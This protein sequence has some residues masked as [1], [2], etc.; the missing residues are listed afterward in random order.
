MTCKLPELEK[1]SQ[2]SQRL[3]LLESLV[4]K[5]SKFTNNW[6]RDCFVVFYLLAVCIFHI[7]G[8]LYGLLTD[9]TQLFIIV[10]LKYKSQVEYRV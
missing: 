1:L 10:D 5:L 8:H 3:I 7:L 2:I 9:L 6:F 4:L